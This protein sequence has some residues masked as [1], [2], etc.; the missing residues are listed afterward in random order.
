MRF[1]EESKSY[2]MVI[3]VKAISKMMSKMERVKLYHKINNTI[4][5]YRHSNGRIYEGE[6][7]DGNANGIGSL[8]FLDGSSIE[9]E[10]KDDRLHGKVVR[11]L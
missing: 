8:R 6:L 1:I 7:K 2:R 9:G 11:I 5:I 4:G 10:W 3:N